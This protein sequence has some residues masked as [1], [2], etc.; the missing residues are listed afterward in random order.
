M[1]SAKGKPIKIAFRAGMVQDRNEENQSKEGSQ[2]EGRIA[3][4]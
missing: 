4:I 3:A 1:K 2:D